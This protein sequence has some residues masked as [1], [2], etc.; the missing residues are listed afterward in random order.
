MSRGCRAITRKIC[1]A[2]DAEI[3]CDLIWSCSRLACP[4]P[5]ALRSRPAVKSL[6]SFDFAAILSLKKTLLE[7]ARSEYATRHENI[8]A[9]GNR[10]LAT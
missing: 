2:D 8:I 5:G 6:D 10:E 7:L 4:S 1:E 3:V 9:A